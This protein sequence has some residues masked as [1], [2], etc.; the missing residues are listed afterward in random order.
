MQADFLTNIYIIT[1]LWM[2][3]CNNTVVSGPGQRKGRGKR[4]NIFVC[5]EHNLSD[6]TYD[7]QF[8]SFSFLCEL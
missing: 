3:L 2:K 1:L 7:A 4:L 6:I 5:R 8:Q